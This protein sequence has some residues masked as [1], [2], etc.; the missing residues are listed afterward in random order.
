MSVPSHIE[1]KIA[2]LMDV[3][4]LINYFSDVRKRSII[5]F[6]NT[7]DACIA[8]EKGLSCPTLNLG[9]IHSQPGSRKRSNAIFLTDKDNANLSKIKNLGANI[10]IRSVPQETSIPLKL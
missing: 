5:L 6:Y 10:G 7:V 3:P 9:N 8:L 2:R 1:L 4:D